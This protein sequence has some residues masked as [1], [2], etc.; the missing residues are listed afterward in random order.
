MQVFST[1]FKTKK[2]NK[3][4]CLLWLHFLFLAAFQSKAAEG[5]IYEF[6]AKFVLK[7]GESVIGK[8]HIYL[9]FDD[10]RFCNQNQQFQY[11]DKNFQK[12]LNWHFYENQHQLK[13]PVYTRFIALTWKNSEPDRR[14]EYANSTAVHFVHLDS[15]K[16]TVFLSCRGTDSCFL[17][18]YDDSTAQILQ[19]KPILETT[20]IDISLADKN[21]GTLGPGEGYTYI[22]LNLNEKYDKRNFRRKKLE[23]AKRIFAP[24]LRYIRSKNANKYEIFMK[25][26]AE[27]A[28]VLAKELLEEY[29]III[30]VEAPPC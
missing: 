29:I 8:T 5:G 7:N 30:T 12:L 18:I 20:E 16:Y 14:Y 9:S 13:F 19:E 17:G 21:E 11:T 22:L 10:N 28:K 15:L 24:E 1:N 4:T 25:E 3:N 27:N 6:K 23:I 2:F 26:R